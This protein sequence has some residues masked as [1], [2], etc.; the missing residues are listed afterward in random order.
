M[1]SYHGNLLRAGRENIQEFGDALDAESSRRVGER[2][3]PNTPS[4]RQ[5]LYRDNAHFSR[6]V[7]RYLDLFGP[8][9]TLILIFEEFA[10][11]TRQEYLK[12]LRFLDLVDDGKTDFPVVNSGDK[13]VRYASLSDF[14]RYPPPA[15][16]KLIRLLIP[17]RKLRVGA[18]GK[19]ARRVL[20]MN[21][22]A[23]KRPPMDPELRAR[24]HAELADEQAALERLLARPLPW[25]SHRADSKLVGGSDAPFGT[26][27]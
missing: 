7:I 24:L 4:P 26:D 22:I 27:P 11:D 6:Q 8:E 23:A 12:T 16:R 19:V 13:R 14:I 9:Q 25:G 18:G 1:Y 20:D 17:S 3:P 5:L 21:T 10:S 2:M 15:A